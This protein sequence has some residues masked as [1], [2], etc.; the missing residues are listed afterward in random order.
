MDWICKRCKKKIDTV[1]AECECCD[2]CCRCD[3]PYIP[4]SAEYYDPGYVERLKGE[5]RL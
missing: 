1:C 4:D 5:G 2:N 3:V